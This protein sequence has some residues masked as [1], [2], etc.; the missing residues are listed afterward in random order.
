MLWTF[1]HIVQP[2]FKVQARVK[3]GGYIGWNNLELNCRGRKVLRVLQ[4]LRCVL[5]G[6]GCLLNMSVCCE[7]F[8]VFELSY[9]SQ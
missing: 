3:K 4:G 1:V 5:S 6:S 9:V 8:E 2:E 7:S